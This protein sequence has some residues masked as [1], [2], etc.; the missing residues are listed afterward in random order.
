RTGEELGALPGA[1]DTR[2]EAQTDTWNFA[3]EQP[4]GHLNPRTAGKFVAGFSATTKI[5]RSEWNLGRGAP[6]ISDEVDVAIEVEAV[7]R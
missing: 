7:R 2:P 4:L 3:G 1:G 6:L 5:L